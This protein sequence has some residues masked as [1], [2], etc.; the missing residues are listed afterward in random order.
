M[1]LSA[2]IAAAGD[3][4]AQTLP[5][6]LAP[7]LQPPINEQ[8]QLRPL[9][10]IKPPP[11]SIITPLSP[12]DQ[13]RDRL[14]APVKFVLKSVALDG[15][16]ILD[17]ESA[18]A[19][20]ASYL[21]RVVDTLDL[22][23]IQQRLTRAL[24][25]K[26]FINSGALLPDQEVSDGVVHFALIAGRLNDV[27]VTGQGDLNP[28]Y[29]AG[30]LRLRAS[31]PLNI[32]DLE[33]AQ[34]LLLAD[35]LFT[36]L[37]LEL[38]P[39]AERGLADL[40]VGVARNSPYSGSLTFANNQSPAAGPEHG[41]MEGSVANLLGFGD[42]LDLRYGRSEGLNDGDVAYSIP[43]AYDDT[44]INARFDVNSSIVIGN[45]FGPLNITSETR[46]YGLGV[47]RPFYRTAEDNLTL[48]IGLERRSSL[49]T[50]LGVPFSLTDGEENGH[51]KETVLRFYQSW[52]E[53]QDDQV[54]ALR[55]TFGFGL[56]GLGG[57]QGFGVA[58]GLFTTWLGQFQ[59]VRKLGLDTEL[60]AR[61]AIQVAAN[62]LFPIEQFGLGGIDSVRGFREN[63]LVTDNAVSASIE[64]RQTVWRAP[65][66][67]L[68]PGQIEDG[69]VQLAAF[70]DFGSG[71]NT[72][73]Q[74]PAGHNLAS[75]G[76]G[77]RYLPFAGSV[78]ELYVGRP[79]HQIKLGNTLQDQGV[80]FRVVL[81]LN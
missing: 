43:V 56:D 36:R 64:L 23:D 32:H 52:I 2:L 24:I 65:L 20:Y 48:G 75:M 4:R 41:A 27:R 62:P 15:E 22:L 6:S 28:D 72:G 77:L 44:R 5:P 61:S 69:R 42:T 73:R 46:T 55:S 25:D 57:T 47:S 49:N 39:G 7:G 18:K 63:Q 14:A 53:R 30:R 9:E 3:M 31:V 51:A 67:A 19:A 11:A 74:T 59:H 38:V 45:P 81:S 10:L 26:G 16:Q 29:L 79:F 35:P 34:Q 71:W 37:N 8:N 76:V 1:L 21:G 66:P 13:T 33:E 60:V 50:L 78:A 17:S 68:S 12:P 40:R 54:T 80:Y 70:A 58:S